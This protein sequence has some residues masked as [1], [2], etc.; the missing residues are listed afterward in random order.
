MSHET[1]ERQRF[2]ATMGTRTGHSVCRRCLPT[3]A[4]TMV[5]LLVMTPSLTFALQTRSLV[6]TL[7]DTMAYATNVTYTFSGYRVKNNET[8]S[9][10]SVTFP[11]DTDVSGAYAMQ[12]AGSASVSGQKV[13]ITFD[14]PLPGL[15]TFDVVIGG[16]KN[17]ST[18][19]IYNVGNLTFDV[20]DKW[21]VAFY[22]DMP[23]GDYTITGSTLT[24]TVDTAMLDFG[25]LLPDE[26]PPAQTVNVTVEADMPYNMTR[27]LAGDVTPLGLTVSGDGQ[28]AKAA[29]TT[30]YLESVGIA[31]GWDAPA[32][33]TLTAQIVYSVT[34]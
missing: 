1:A 8:T 12:P 21:G 2:G 3:C 10:V 11:A 13:T 15:T 33:T 18:A 24:L 32:D 7:T 9:K 26:V 5:L 30:T 28:G 27:T 22:E 20:L 19:G 25:T 16:I 6:T 23:T 31:P 29:G 4:L 14:A 34:P 17:P